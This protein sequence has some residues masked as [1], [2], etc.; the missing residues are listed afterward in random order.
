MVRAVGF[1]NNGH[2]NIS[3]TRAA[4]VDTIRLAFLCVSERPRS[5]ARLSSS[6]NRVDDAFGIESGACAK[7]HRNG[8]K[9]LTCTAYVYAALTHRALISLSTTNTAVATVTIDPKTM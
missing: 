6:A 3:P 8:T 1:E 4:S 2:C 9:V 5:V 7:S